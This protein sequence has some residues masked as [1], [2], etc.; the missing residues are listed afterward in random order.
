MKKYSMTISLLTISLLV[1]LLTAPFAFA[2]SD[3]DY[4]KI[5]AKSAHFRTA[6]KYLAQTWQE[7]TKIMSAADFNKLKAEQKQWIA[8]GRDKDA[9]AMHKNMDNVSLADA[10]ALGTSMRNT[11]ITGLIKWSKG[12]AKGIKQDIYF[13]GDTNYLIVA[14]GTK[15]NTYRISF[16][17]ESWPLNGLENG[18]NTG[19]YSGTAP[20]NGNKLYAYDKTVQEKPVFTII[21]KD[22]NN[23]T[24]TEDPDS[25]GTYF[26]QNVYASG[27]YKKW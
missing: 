16:Y 5:R 27:N 12:K 17:G 20:K 7:A 2:L 10:Y 26:G 24:I 23:I 3:S 8:S 11:K 22:A 15:P 1:V 14:Q 13:C 6:E 19:E 25:E 18:P 9:A 21:F 4:N